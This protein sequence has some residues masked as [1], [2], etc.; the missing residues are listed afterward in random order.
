[1]DSFKPVIS[2][3]KKIKEGK[4]KPKQ[5]QTIFKKCQVILLSS[6]L[7]GASA[8]WVMI[9]CWQRWR[10]TWRTYRSS[11]QITFLLARQC[12]GTPRSS[13]SELCRRA[14]AA[15]LQS[16]S[17][18]ETCSSTALIISFFCCFTGR[19]Y[20]DT[21]FLLLHFLSTIL[22]CF[23][24]C[25]VQL[26]FLHKG[27]QNY[28]LWGRSDYHYWEV[29]LCKYVQ[30]WDIIEHIKKIS[31]ILLLWFRRFRSPCRAVRLAAKAGF[32]PLCDGACREGTDYSSVN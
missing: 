6:D 24:I 22:R 5:K 31:V 27:E 7:S 9:T 26:R 14:A 3:N 23:Q 13:A 11:P 32:M 4:R 17:W 29:K 1:M 2:A 18:E 28:T 8:A 19:R 20:A 30:S 15:A 21:V 10:F 25:S 12:R 16:I